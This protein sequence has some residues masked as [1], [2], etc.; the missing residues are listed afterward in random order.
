MKR[1]STNN[2]IEKTS[3]RKWRRMKGMPHSRNDRV[4]R[5]VRRLMETVNPITGKIYNRKEISEQTGLS[6]QTINRILNS[7]EGEVGLE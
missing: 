6:W 5:Q 2:Y 4:K 1:I 3:G 7:T